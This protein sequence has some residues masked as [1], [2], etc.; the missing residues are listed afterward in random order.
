MK[1]PVYFFDIGNTRLKLWRCRE[2]RV[3]AHWA[4]VHAGAPARLLQEELP[5]TFADQPCAV[6]GISVL[7]TAADGDFSRAVEQR[8][9][10]VP[11]YARAAAEF[12]GLRSAYHEA[13]ERLGVDRWLGLIGAAG[14]CD[15]L[16]VVGCGTAVTIDVVSSGVHLGGYILPGLGLMETALLQGTGRVRFDTTPPRTV[17]LG[18]DTATAV[19]NGALAAVAAL[20]ERTVARH[21]VQRLVLTGGDAEGVAAALGCT[22][23]VEPDLLLKG[24]MR[25]F[26]ELPDVTDELAPEQPGGK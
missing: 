17:V 26:D 7:G 6:A 8:W 1:A 12:R 22:A 18:T 25:Y 4:A 13:P 20:V 23:T 14:D 16:C 2:G 3:E 21:E 15:A 10:L 11:T 19:R 9:R 5:L 24:M